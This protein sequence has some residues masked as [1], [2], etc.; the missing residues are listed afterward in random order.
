MRRPSFSTIRG[1]L[2]RHRGLLLVTIL[3]LVVRLVWNLWIHNPANYAYSDM[4]G[5]ISRADEMITRPW[6]PTKPGPAP[7]LRFGEIVDWLAPRLFGPKSGYLTLYPYGTHGFI[8]LVKAV[9]G[10]GNKI[11]LGAAF[12]VIGALSV[13]FSYA[14]A[15]RLSPRRRVRRVVAGILIFYYPWISL[16]GYALS[17]APF[18]LCI[19]AIAF[20]GLRLADEGRRGDAWRLGIW[21]ALGTVVRPQVLV[22]VGFLGLLFLLRRRA[23]RHFRPMMAV[24]VALPL[25]L[26]MAVSAWRI[27][28]HMGTKVDADHLISTNGPLNRVFGRCHN[29]R[30]EAKAKDGKGFFGPPA[31]GALLHYEKEHPNPVFRLDPAMGEVIVFSGH[32]WE[33]EPNKQLA[34]DCV[35]KTGPWR[36][37][38][39]AVTHVIL[40][41][42]YNIIW[43]DMGEKPRFRYTMAAFCVAHAIVIMPPAVLAMVLAFR[44]RRARW[45]LLALHVWGLFLTSMLY[46]GDTRYRAPY[47]GILTVLAI[48]MV[49]Q[50]VGVLRRGWEWVRY[51]RS[52]KR[53]ISS[54]L[55][56]SGPAP[57]APSAAAMA[58]SRMR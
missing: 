41:W 7:H 47:D 10:K 20:Y 8:G 1:H 52:S 56:G 45:M 5:Y 24:G 38:K 30:L 33:A 37:V 21:L 51:R 26:T 55:P 4:G 43:P 27:H 31:F 28:W 19:S 18:T 54:S 14:T 22:S 58:A 29:I 9:F 12:A 2:R 34:K 3:A 53:A 23:F 50:I 11:A 46:F 42:G 44:R 49:P 39:Y 57:S 16:G 6:L 40:L 32:M 48:A 17:E 15:A 35:A 36:Q 13:A 25:A